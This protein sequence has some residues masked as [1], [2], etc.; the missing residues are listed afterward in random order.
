MT[1]GVLRSSVTPELE[2]VETWL[3]SQP[4]VLC[5]RRYDGEPPSWTACARSY[6]L[7]FVCAKMRYEV[8]AAAPITPGLSAGLASVFDGLESPVLATT[9]VPSFIAFLRIAV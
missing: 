2:S 8:L 3:S 9:T 4:G 1:S 6:R 5:P 7:R